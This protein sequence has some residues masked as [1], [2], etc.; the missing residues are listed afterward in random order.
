MTSVLSSISLSPEY[1]LGFVVAAVALVALKRIVSTR[2]PK[3][4]IGSSY[5]VP[6]SPVDEKSERPFGGTYSG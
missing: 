6:S 4:K 5:S 3:A 2:S 1:F